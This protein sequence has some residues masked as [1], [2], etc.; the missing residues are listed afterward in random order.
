MY[1]NYRFDDNEPQSLMFCIG[2][3]NR[4]T[5]NADPSRRDNLSF[6]QDADRRTPRPILNRLLPRVHAPRFTDCAPRTP[7]TELLR[8]N[9][10]RTQ[11][12]ER[13]PRRR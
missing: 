7:S 9:E 8:P 2:T 6:W 1:V 10:L 12:Y 11:N 5:L 13:V 3:E 4:R